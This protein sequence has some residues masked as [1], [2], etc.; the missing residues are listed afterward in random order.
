[1]E[2]LN[3]KWNLQLFSQAYDSFD[4]IPRPLP[5]TWHSP[6]LKFEWNQFLMILCGCRKT[7][8]WAWFMTWHTNY[9]TDENT[10][11]ALKELYNSDYVITR[12]ELPPFLN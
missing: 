6:L 4:Q 8:P 3:R 5:H 9:V 12:D 1:M 7:T 11:E 10:K 2:A